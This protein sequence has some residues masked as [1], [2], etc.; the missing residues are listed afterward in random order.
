MDHIDLSK[1]EIKEIVQEQD[2]RFDDLI[3]HLLTILNDRS[4]PENQKQSIRKQFDEIMRLK[5]ITMKA[6]TIVLVPKN[7]NK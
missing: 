6:P 5:N 4:I 1:Y 7:T 2:D 3:K